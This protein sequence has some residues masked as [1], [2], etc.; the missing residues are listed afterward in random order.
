MATAMGPPP[1]KPPSAP[2]S[3]ESSSLSL[4]SIPDSET[5]EGVVDQPCV[6]QCANCRVVFGDTLSLVT[7]V[8]EAGIVC[9]SAGNNVSVNSSVRLSQQGPDAGCTFQALHCAPCRARVGSVYRTTSAA[10]DL[11]R[12][13]YSFSRDAVTSYQLGSAAPVSQGGWSGTSPD[14]ALSRM[15]GLVDT[16]SSHDERILELEAVMRALGAEVA[17]LEGAVND[18]TTAASKV[19]LPKPNEGGDRVKRRRSGDSRFNPVSGPK[20][21]RESAASTSRTSP[22]LMMIG[23]SGSRR[24][25][26]SPPDG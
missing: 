16:V 12:D 18:A 17:R 6:I 9:L 22:S 1:L 26:L 25:S 13:L 10:L 23:Q 7:L 4:R 19:G 15:P 2:P 24:V 5:D 14:A 3:F 8:E 11:T 20:R 21:S